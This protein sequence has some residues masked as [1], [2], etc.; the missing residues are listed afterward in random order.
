M[1][2]LK[3]IWAINMFVCGEQG[4]LTNQTKHAATGE[5]KHKQGHG[6]NGRPGF[7]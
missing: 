1:L 5:L 6:T 3:L 2:M 7:N 4:F